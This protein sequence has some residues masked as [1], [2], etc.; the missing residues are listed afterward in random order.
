MMFVM[1]AMVFLGLDM[2]LAA[3]RAQ[4]PAPMSVTQWME[5]QG[6]KSPRR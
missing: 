1:V 4:Q 3:L 2:F 6:T 5:H